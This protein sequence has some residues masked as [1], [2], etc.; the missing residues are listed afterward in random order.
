MAAPVCTAPVSG[1]L[2]PEQVRPGTFLGAAMPVQPRPRSARRRRACCATAVPAGVEWVAPAPLAVLASTVASPTVAT[3]VL[4]MPPIAATLAMVSPIVSPAR[5]DPPRRLICGHEAAPYRVTGFRS[6]AGAGPG[7]TA[8]LGQDALEP[9]LGLTVHMGHQRPYGRMDRADLGVHLVGHGPIARMAFASRAQ[10][11]QL[12]RLAGVEVEDEAD[13]VA[14]AER[15]R[16]RGGEPGVDEAVVLAGRELE[17]AAVLVAAAGQLDLLGDAGAQIGGER[18]PLDSQH[19]VA[20]Q[21]AESTVVG[22]DLEAVAKRLEAAPGAVAPVRPIAGEIGQQR[23]ARV[24]VER[25]DGLVDP[26]LAARPRLEQQRGEQIVLVALG[27]Q[28]GDR[29]TAGW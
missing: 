16:R 6:G 2:N 28:K 12:H 9:G 14:Q 10:L 17:R 29:G 1:G 24:G 5:P 27:A 4:M 20:L 11:D 15:V 25:P 7:V 22:D 21:I 13:P 26:L 19:P 3:Q 23:G 8:H 18:L